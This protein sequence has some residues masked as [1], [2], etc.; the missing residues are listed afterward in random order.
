MAQMLN[1]KFSTLQIIHTAATN[2]PV[3]EMLSRDFST[4]TNTTCHL[5]HKA[6]PLHIDFLQIKPNNYLK[7]IHYLVK[8]E[9]V[10]TTQK[11]I[12]TPF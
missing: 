12:H 2:P 11:M 3:A 10:L 4:I 9:D 7:L 1:T 5:Q 8:H 6:L